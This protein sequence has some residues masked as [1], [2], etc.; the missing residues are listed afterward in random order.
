[1]KTILLLSGYMKSGKDTVGDYL[2]KNYNFQ[3]FAFADCLK[4]QVA[5][6][7]NIDRSL[8]D[9]QKGKESRTIVNNQ[10]ISIRQLLIN[11]GKEKRNLDI[12]YWVNIVSKDILKSDYN[13]IVI[14]DWRFP[15]EYYK[16]CENFQNTGKVLT[17][18]INRLRYPLLNDESETSLD[19]FE[20]NAVI[21]NTTSD[22]ETLYNEIENTFE[23]SIII[24]SKDKLFL[25]DVDDTLLKWVSGFINFIKKLN[26][27]TITKYPQSWMMTNWISNSS[28]Y[29]VQKDEILTLISLFNKSQEFS[30][31]AKYDNAFEVLTKFKNRN[32]KIIAITSC[33]ND[34]ET[35][36]NRQ[37]NLN[38][39]FPDL[40]DKLICLPLGSC[41]KK[42]LEMYKSSI[43]LDDNFVNVQQ[44][45]DLGHL[46]FMVCHSWNKDLSGDFKKITDLRELLEYME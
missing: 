13:K 22:L 2:V 17:L 7:Y 12:N 11:H 40:I 9:T 29:P 20:F 27:K 37:E 6:I 33:N 32:Y 23:Y 38:K 14:T 4:N 34:T 41:K 42:K 35:Q 10:E 25:T 39:E 45:H 46:S 24:D 18:R 15:N 21:S 28:G 43:W 30:K 31:L 3:R 8:L 26:Y 44:G 1:M 5:E 19:N 36:K 16:I